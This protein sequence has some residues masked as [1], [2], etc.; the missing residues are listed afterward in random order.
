VPTERE[1]TV[2]GFSVAGVTKAR[3][4]LAASAS[5]LCLT[6]IVDKMTPAAEEQATKRYPIKLKE[7]AAFVA[8]TPHLAGMPPCEIKAA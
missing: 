7:L 1:A 6:G 4:L 2:P 5:V 3:Q 8:E